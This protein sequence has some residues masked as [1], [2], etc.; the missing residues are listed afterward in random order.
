MKPIDAKRE[1]GAALLAL[2]AAIMLGASWLL[3]SQLNAESRGF[4]A[5]NRAR[6]AEVLNR[7][8]QALI[9]YVAATAATAGENNPGRLPCPEHAW[10]VGNSDKE[11]VAGPS[12]G[13][14]SPGFGSS[15]CASIGRL[16]WRTLGLEKLVDAAS[17][18]LWYVVR[19]T[20]RLTTS[21][22]AL[23]INSNTAGDITV[24]GEQVVALIIAPGAAMNAQAATGCTAQNQARSAPAA[25]MNATNY[26][27]CFNS[28]FS[29]FVTT[30]SSTS[31]NDQAVRI[32]VADIMP[33]IEAVIANRIEREILPALKTVYTPAAWG[34]ATGANPVLP[35]AA[36]FASP[37]SGAGTSSYQGSSATYAGLLPFNQT[38]GCTE[39][40]SNPRCTTATTGGTAFLRFSKSGDDVQTAGSGSIRTQSS[41]AWQ[42]T[43]Y[44][45]TGEYNQPSISLTFTLNVTNIAMGLRAFDSS[46]VTCTAVDDVG[47]G[48]PTQTVTCSSS[49]ALR[50]NG[51]ARLTVTTNALPDI[52]GSGWGTYANYMINIPRAAFGDHSL[53]STTNATTGWFA[54]N[55]WYRLTYYA[56][57]ASN[58]ASRLPAERSCTTVGDCLTLTAGS[59]ASSKSALLVLAGRSVNGRTRPSATLTDYFEFGNAKAAYESQTVTPVAATIYA[60]TGAANAYTVAATSLASGAIL[61]FRAANAN[62]GASTLNTTATGTRSL[63][64]L[65]GSN[66]ASSTIQ[67]NAAVQVT[68]DG[69][70]FLLAKRPFN[71]RV[72]AIGSN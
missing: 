56:I 63:V 22:S 16:P 1:R 64:N 40:A 71:D 33:A 13:V 39:S 11:G 66:L 23:L 5:V 7:A 12:V 49:V 70:Q 62:T 37:G 15:D 24:D 45:C 60:D 59:G 57:A 47:N 68:W 2:L 28:D 34:M 18:P 69:T 30:A 32:T 36:P 4:T 72:V 9:G 27:E 20:W 67:A 38:Q 43:T 52:S 31:Y 50:S 53:L 8:K 58:T 61:Q 17:E 3:V 48:L 21:T 42:S 46:Q 25:S 44:V 19:P 29:Q 10:Y 41:C 55:E 6:N 51:A 14:T 35:Y 54:R 26:I 65:D